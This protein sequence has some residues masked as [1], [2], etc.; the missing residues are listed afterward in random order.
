MN[1]LP[2]PGGPD[3]F[4]P[5]WM[6]QA[7][8]GNG[9][10][11]NNRVTRVEASLIGEGVGFIGRVARVRLEYERA[12][13]NAPA[14]LIAKFP[15]TEATAKGIG[16][17]LR[18]YEM[19]IRVYDD[20][21]DAPL[22]KPKRYYSDMRLDTNEYILLIEDMAPAP[23]GEQLA[24]CSAEHAR[25]IVP[26]LAAFHAHFWESPQLE[27]L[28]WMPYYNDASH[29]HAQAS[30]Q[31]AWP[32]FQQFVR[33]KLPSEVREA[34]ER[35][36]NKVVHL[37]NLLSEPPITVMHGD[38]RLDNL[39]F[40]NDNA[41]DIVAL[42]WQITSRG[43]GAFDLGYFLC[44]SLS[45]ADRAANEHEL[46]RSYVD[47]LAAGGVRDYGIDA[48]M[49]DYR[50]TAMFNWVYTVIVIGSLDTGNERGVALF[51]EMLGR[52]TAAIMELEAN[53]VI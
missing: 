40:P 52:S 12:D 4:T 46:V 10:I 50:I 11:N 1:N 37:Q 15:A 47:T 43:R 7:L 18:F 6:T 2:I 48:C 8:C 14:S 33:D 39:V 31:L 23:V 22:R 30:Y 36:T 42:D 13:P 3:A 34:G 45:P 16:V 44:T 5:Q 25:A 20:L 29:Q 28:A 9:V 35:L 26:Q 49:R 17:A 19:E 27:R 32:P 38:F 51:H 41:R 24:G 21:G 53:K